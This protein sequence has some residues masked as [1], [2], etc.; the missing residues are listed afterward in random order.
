MG[1]ARTERA[2]L[3]GEEVQVLNMS[4]AVMNTYGMAVDVAARKL[5]MA[6]F[7][8]PLGRVEQG[9]KRVLKAFKS[10]QNA[11]KSAYNSL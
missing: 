11:F 10:L 7:E 8:K 6:D 3:D 9:P 2:S 5:V 4:W 1:R